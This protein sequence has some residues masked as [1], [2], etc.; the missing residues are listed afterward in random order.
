LNSRKFKNLSNW[1]RQMTGFL[2]IQLAL[3][4]AA[5]GPLFA[6]DRISLQE[7]VERMA[8]NQTAQA[9]GLKN[10]TSTR[11]YSLHNG[12]FHRTAE[13]TVKLT[14]SY[15]G[16]KH[17]EVLSESGPRP[18]CDKVLR[19]MVESE[20][21]VSGDELRQFNRITPENYDFRLVRE[22]RENG[23]TAYVIE[24]IPKTRSK[25]LLKGEIWVDAEDFA[26]A[27]IAAQPAKSPSFWIRNSRFEYRY[28]KLGSFWLPVSTDSE[29]DA[30]LFGHTEVQIRY[31]DYRINPEQAERTNAS[32]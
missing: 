13:L 7:I 22:D 12:R 24:T 16:R 21:E 32:Q 27:R 10:Y 18:V 1:L 14:Y 15:P 8:R 28:S 26:I 5:A 17:F 31:G 23:R 11:T 4:L 9:Q 19:R 6:E 3:L 29:A 25:Y 20:A 2:R 30:M